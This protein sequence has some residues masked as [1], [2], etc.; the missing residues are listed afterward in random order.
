MSQILHALLT[1]LVIAGCSAPDNVGSIGGAEMGEVQI[2]SETVLLRD[3]V[4]DGFTIQLPKGWH[5]LAYTA[6]SFDISYFIMQTAS[7]D[8]N[9][10]IF[11]GDPSIPMFFT[12]DGPT[13]EM[14]HLNSR[15]NPLIRVAPLASAEQFTP[16]YVKRKF[17]KLEGFELVSTKQSPEIVDRLNAQMQKSG[18]RMDASA[19]VVHFRFK[20]GAKTMNTLLY[21]HVLSQPGIWTFGMSGIASANDPQKLYDLLI[22]IVDSV[23]TNPEWRAK[24]DAIHQQK[25]AQIAAQGRLAMQGM[26]E[27]HQ[28]RMNAIR[29][30]GDASMKAYYDRSNAS[31]LQHRNFLNYI[32]DETTVVNSAG[33]AFQVTNSYQRYY[34]HKGN[35]TYVGGDSTTDLESLRRM[36]FNPDDYEEVKVRRSGG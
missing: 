26:A 25:M 30:Q 10:V 33:K 6:R 17:G 31:D 1:T 12:P 8:G 14:A 24:Q 16:D 15:Y 21:G 4:E 22:K 5:N 11:S 35:G 3:P 19:A 2:P 23:K 29:A 32:N 7:P 9:S 27:R 20:Q 36:G 34:M 18:F 28:I 13:A